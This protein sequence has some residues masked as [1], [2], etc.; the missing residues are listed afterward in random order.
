[1]LLVLRSHLVTMR[2]MGSIE[3]A[4]GAG[5]SWL[6]DPARA[7]EIRALMT[8]GG[9]EEH[10]LVFHDPVFHDPVFHDPV[11][12]DRLGAD[13]R[14]FCAPVAVVEEMSE[15]TPGVVEFSMKSSPYCTRKRSGRT[16][17]WNF[18]V[19]VDD[20]SQVVVSRRSPSL[21]GGGL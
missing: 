21:H 10:G 15:N 12:H 14:V 19:S 2:A 17:G 16:L 7:L 11:F 5:F 1:V 6:T 8:P 4:S 9:I 3:R 20:G 18:V 13:P